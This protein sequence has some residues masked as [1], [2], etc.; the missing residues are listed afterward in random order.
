MQLNVGAITH[1]AAFINEGLNFQESYM[2]FPLLSCLHLT[3]CKI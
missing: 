1:V 2:I 3:K